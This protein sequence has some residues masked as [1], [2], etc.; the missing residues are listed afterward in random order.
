MIFTYGDSHANRNFL[1]A[2]INK[3]IIDK[4]QSSVTMFRIGRDN[5]IINFDKN[6][7]NDSSILCFNYGEVD[8]RCH[9]KRQINLGKNEDDIIN[10]LVENYFITI[11]NNIKYYK[12]IIIVAIIPPTKKIELESIHGEITHEFPFVGTD[13]ERVRYTEKMNNL[14]KIYCNKYN[15]VYFDPFY[16]YKRDD[17]TIKFELTDTIG[18]LLDNSFFLEEFMKI[19]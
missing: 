12:K 7:H 15:F 1:N 8:C 9:I 2:Q 19:I 5:I 4:H 10:D 13:D 18:H 14:L 17:G 11:N 3:Q 6:D 16:F